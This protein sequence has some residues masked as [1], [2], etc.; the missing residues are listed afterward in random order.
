MCFIFLVTGYL[1][2]FLMWAFLRRHCTASHIWIWWEFW[3]QRKPTIYLV[4]AK[5]VSLGTTQHTSHGRPLTRGQGSTSH[6]DDSSGIAF[7][8]SHTPTWPGLYFKYFKG[9]EGLMTLTSLLLGCAPG[10][11]DKTGNAVAREVLP[12]CPG[13]PGTSWAGATRPGP[14]RPSCTRGRRERAPDLWTG[15]REEEDRAWVSTVLVVLLFLTIR[16]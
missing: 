4:L 3:K 14:S 13:G 9:K 8:L 1:T 6:V 2:E 5:I 10:L 16:N 11:Q 7:S 12:A 15:D